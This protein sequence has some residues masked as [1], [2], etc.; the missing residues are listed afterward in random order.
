MGPFL[1]TLSALAAVAHAAYCNGAPGPSAHVNAYPVADGLASMVLLNTVPNGRAYRAGPPGFEFTVLSLYGSA[2]EKGF[3]H[4]SL[5]T[6]DVRAM[7]N[8][9]WAYMMG[10]F[11]GA[12]SFLPPWLAAIVADVGLEVAL[13]VFVNLTTPF[14]GSYIYDELHGIADGAG[15]DF[16]TIARI[17]LIGELTQGDCSMVGAFGSATA[18]GKTL[19]MRALDWDTDGPFKHFPAVILYN[20]SGPEDGHAFANVGFLGWIGALT[21]MSLNLGI[22]EI[23]VSYPDSTYFGANG[24]DPYAVGTPF[25]FLLRDM[26]Q[27][28]ASYLDSVKRIETSN[29]TCD[30]ILGVTDGVANTSRAFAYSTAEAFVFDSTT[31]Q[32]WNATGTW[33]PRIPDVVYYGM[34]WLCPG[35]TVPLAKELQALHGSLSPENIVA[36]VPALVQTGDLHVAV[37]DLTDRALFVSFMAPDPATVPQLAYDRAYTRLDLRTLFAMPPPGPV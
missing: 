16:N 15:V 33:H 18:G 9:T 22:N 24:S 20:P 13:D 29:R 7:V 27:F 19:G 3:A 17:H 23:G 34:D 21:G 26:M 8:T 14:T 5:V 12:L 31:L 4:G 10:Q 25:V 11:E 6:A 35:Y 30:L 32:P 1:Q 36:N 2:Y 28:D 37:Y